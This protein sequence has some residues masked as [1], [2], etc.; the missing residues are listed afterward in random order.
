M[1][2]S[3]SEPAAR[4]TQPPASRWVTWRNA[5][6]H[7]EPVSSRCTHGAISVATSDHVH[8]VAV[9]LARGL[10]RQ[11]RGDGGPQR[12]CHPLPPWPFLSLQRGDGMAKEAHRL[13]EGFCLDRVDLV[14][15]FLSTLPPETIKSSI[16]KRKSQRWEPGSRAV[17]TAA[18]SAERDLQRR[19]APQLGHSHSKPGRGPSLRPEE[20]N[21][22]GSEILHVTS[23][24]SSRVEQ[25]FVKQLP[26]LPGSQVNSSVSLLETPVLSA[27]A[28]PESY[29]AV[30]VCSLRGILAS[31]SVPGTQWVASE[32][33]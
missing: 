25:P 18:D 20:D 28:H 21:C 2:T 17:V 33:F 11:Q 14:Q 30:G 12:S 4:D 9:E 6:H 26:S 32:S 23:K 13:W 1:P 16:T 31:C 22:Q 19:K 27:T 7:S 29:C 5:L 3:A 24:R 10:S 15:A 8:G